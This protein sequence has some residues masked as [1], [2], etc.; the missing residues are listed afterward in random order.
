MDEFTAL[1]LGLY[2]EVF[3]AFSYKK[4]YLDLVFWY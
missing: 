2:D 4:Q 1:I 3:T